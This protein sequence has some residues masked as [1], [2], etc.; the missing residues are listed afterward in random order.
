VLAL[1]GALALLA[2]RY[3]SRQ[4]LVRRVQELEALAEAGRALS[5]AELDVDA[6]CE[7]IFDQA[8]K[9]V[10][11]STFQ[12]GLF[13]DD[14]YN[15]KLWQIEG[16]RQRPQMFDLSDGEGI[17]AWMRRTGQALR[18]P[19]SGHASNRRGGHPKLFARRLFGNT[20]PA[21][22][23]HCRA[24]RLRHCPRPLA[25]KRAPARQATVAHCRGQPPGRGD[26]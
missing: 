19:A 6:L 3:L 13:E 4:A 5:V 10:D 8:S 1:L 11:T 9:I 7:L 26:F 14:H 2:R 16:V 18:A 25:G 17:I 24:G 20:H 22:V 23:Y 15:I 12:L 21:A